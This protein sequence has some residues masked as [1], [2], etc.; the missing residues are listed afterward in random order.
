MQ[1]KYNKIK[2]FAQIVPYSNS[3]LKLLHILRN[4][5]INNLT[6]AFFENQQQTSIIYY[7][8]ILILYIYYNI[9]IILLIFL[10]HLLKHQLLNC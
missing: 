8:Y 5:T 4:L 1:K 10:L 7:N 6:I 3:N 9:Y 2:S